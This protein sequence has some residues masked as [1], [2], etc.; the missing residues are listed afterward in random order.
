[1]ASEL[2]G[3]ALAAGKLAVTQCKDL[4]KEIME[5]VSWKSPF[6][7]LYSIVCPEESENPLDAVYLDT[8]NLIFSACK[9]LTPD[10]IGS[11]KTIRPT[12]R[13]SLR[14]QASTVFF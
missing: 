3:Q 6:L 12:E 4:L 1:M 11:L 10:L 9:T 2:F 13:P 14:P 8:S 5:W 7:N